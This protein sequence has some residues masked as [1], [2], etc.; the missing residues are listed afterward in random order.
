MN[1]TV[2]PENDSLFRIMSRIPGIDSG[3][4]AAWRL[5]VLKALGR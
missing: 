5:E 2:S 3:E 4:R 1:G